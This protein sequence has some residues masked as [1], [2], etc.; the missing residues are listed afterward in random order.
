MNKT[1]QLNLDLRTK[2][3]EYSL[4]LEDEINE[5]IK[6]YLGISNPKLKSLGNNSSNLSLRNKIDILHDLEIFQGDIY[7][8][9]VLFMEFRNQ[10]IHNINCNTFVAALELLKDDRGNKLLKLANCNPTDQRELESK[11]KKG[12]SELF[13]ICFRSVKQIYEARLKQFQER[14]KLVFSIMDYCRYI[15]D[16][17]T[18]LNEQ[19]LYLC[20][21]ISNKDSI[22]SLTFKTKI[23]EL[24]T[25]F[26]K[27]ITR[28]T[29]YNNL[30]E[31]MDNNIDHV[32]SYF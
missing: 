15:I 1:K 2:V 10:F 26:T 4:I 3:L 29:E 28:N 12:Y 8:N 11:Y 19:I 32:M 5:A 18:E 24:I 17:D 9:F 6:H 25:D 23:A 22:E 14:K 7:S 21:D 16:K 13:I 31:R 30:S 27:S 20:Q